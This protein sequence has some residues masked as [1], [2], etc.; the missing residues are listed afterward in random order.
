MMK[1]LVPVDLISF[2]C[3]DSKLPVHVVERQHINGRPNFVRK[4]D[5]RC[6]HEC[7]NRVSDTDV[8]ST[9]IHENNMLKQRLS[10]A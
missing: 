1:F 2:V 5:V 3:F 6:E 8:I 4:S 10:V 9:L 7:G